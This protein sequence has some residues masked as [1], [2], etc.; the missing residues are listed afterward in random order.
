MAQEVNERTNCAGADSCRR[1]QV[2]ETRQQRGLLIKIIAFVRFAPARPLLDA[3]EQ[4]I[5]LIAP[6]FRF[7]YRLRVHLSALAAQLIEAA[8]QPPRLR[9]LPVVVEPR[10]GQQFPATRRTL[11]NRIH[12][13]FSAE[14]AD[15]AVEH[16]G[17][18]RLRRAVGTPRAAEP[19][20]QVVAKTI[21]QIP[22]LNAAL[23]VH[24]LQLANPRD[25]V[26]AGQRKSTRLANAALQNPAD[27]AFEVDRLVQRRPDASHRARN[28]RHLAWQ[29]SAPQVPLEKSNGF[30]AISAERGAGEK[31]QSRIIFVD[32]GNQRILAGRWREVDVDPLEELAR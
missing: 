11:I 24:L 12:V 10:R 13:T 21:E 25:D 14:S 17:H 19:I 28:R 29:A 2:D 31:A 7:P 22:S 1:G 18:H 9:S 5:G 32:R 8:M 4:Q 3:G 20:D 30:A 6:F 15:D 27:D 26:E 23:A 16:R